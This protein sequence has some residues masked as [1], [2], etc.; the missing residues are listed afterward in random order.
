M[1]GTVMKLVSG[2]TVTRAISDPA[3]SIAKLVAAEKDDAKVCSQGLGH[4]CSTIHRGT[5]SNAH[6]NPSAPSIQSGFNQFSRS[7]SSG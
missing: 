6:D 2:P 4:P 1:L 3:N 5:S 7:I